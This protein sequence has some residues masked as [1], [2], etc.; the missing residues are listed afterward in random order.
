MYN[1]CV[2]V[3]EQNLTITGCFRER[4]TN[5]CFAWKKRSDDRGNG[6]WSQLP[7]T[8]IPFGNREN[9]LRQLWTEVFL[10]T[11]CMRTERRKA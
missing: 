5:D 2:K 8:I 1:V 4:T 10:T 3:C 6:L 9:R 11:M 7:S